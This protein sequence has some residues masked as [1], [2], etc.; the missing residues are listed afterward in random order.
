MGRL[1]ITNSLK[2]NEIHEEETNIRHPNTG[3]DESF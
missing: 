1:F 3:D 2:L